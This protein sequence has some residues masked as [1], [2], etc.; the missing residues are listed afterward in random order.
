VDNFT[1]IDHIAPNCESHELYKGIYADDSKGV[2]SGTIIVQR[3]AQKTNAYQSNASLLL[4]DTSESSSK[5]QLK[6]WADDVKCSHGATGG[7]LDEEALFYLRA[8]GITEKE[9]KAILTRAYVSDVLE[10][11][12]DETLKKSVENILEQKLAQIL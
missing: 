7:Q 1:V 12:E 10:H 2:F 9:A 8:R 4:S 3:E 11:L 5:P 6:I